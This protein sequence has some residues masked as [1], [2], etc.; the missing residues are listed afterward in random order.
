MGKSGGA[1]DDDLKLDRFGAPLGAFDPGDQ[2]VHRIDVGGAPDLGDHDHVQPVA[3]FF[4]QVHDIAIPIG[5]VQPVYPHR[6]C[7]LAP[8]DV[9]DGVDHQF[10]GRFLVVRRDC[11]FQVKVDHVR[12]RGCHF[13]GQFGVR[14]G[15]EQ[16]TPIGACGGLGLNAERHGSL[17]GAR[18][19]LLG[20][21]EGYEI[22][23]WPARG[24]CTAAS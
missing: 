18:K 10:A 13:R 20:C 24:F 12:G 14:A 17:L 11:V 1:F 6:Q 23:Q 7:L 4:Q 21:P 15:S 9:A 5:R 8:V 3:G 2:G 16:L 22:A 19:L